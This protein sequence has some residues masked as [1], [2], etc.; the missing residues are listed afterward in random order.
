MAAAGEGD[1]VGEG[2]QQR[3][4]NG[5]WPAGRTWGRWWRGHIRCQDEPASSA[6]Q[7]TYDTSRNVHLIH[8]CH[9]ATKWSRHMR[10]RW[11]SVNL[12]VEKRYVQ[13]SKRNGICARNLNKL[14][15]CMHNL[16]KLHNLSQLHNLE[17]FA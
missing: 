10:V 17:H 11:V 1:R 12:L 16:S 6:M 4:R 3:W 7:C 13:K 2:G 14:R 5:R 9:K 8:D 15:D